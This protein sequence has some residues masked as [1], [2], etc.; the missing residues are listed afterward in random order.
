MPR[1]CTFRSFF[2]FPNRSRRATHAAQKIG[3]R[4]PLP[5]FHTRELHRSWS[6]SR[7]KNHSRFVILY[8]SFSSEHMCTKR[9]KQVW[10]E[11]RVL[12]CWFGPDHVRL[13]FSIAMDHGLLFHETTKLD[14]DLLLRLKSWTPLTRVSCSCR[15]LGRVCARLPAISATGRTSR[16]IRQPHP[17]A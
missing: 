12:R 10:T 11:N 16:R 4:S 8:I 1:Y 6:L 3:F 5:Y 14:G 13:E 7:K 17:L 9:N 15:H 2:P